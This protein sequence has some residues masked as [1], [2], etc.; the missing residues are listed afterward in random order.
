MLWIDVSQPNETWRAKP[1]TGGMPAKVFWTIADHLSAYPLLIAPL[2]DDPNFKIASANVQE[3]TAFCDHVQ[4][5]SGQVTLCS[6]E[7]AVC[8]LHESRLGF[9]HDVVQDEMKSSKRSLDVRLCP[10]QKICFRNPN[11][12]STIY[13][14]KCVCFCVYVCEV[15]GGVGV[16]VQCT[17]SVKDLLGVLYG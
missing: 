15:G 7:F 9:A 1:A 14:G 11:C 12:L 13:C 6:D 8:W 3:D 2:R 5:L 17:E 10:P 16:D 4:P